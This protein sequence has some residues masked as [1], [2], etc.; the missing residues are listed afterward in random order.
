MEQKET[1]LNPFTGREIIIGGRTY[2]LVERSL[3]N[4]LREGCDQEPQARGR[5]YCGNRVNIP[6]GYIRA[7][8]KYECLRK[9][10]G[11]GKCGVY[12]KFNQG[13]I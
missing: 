8:T 2:R 7:G 6:E 11:A 9:G 13:F 5:V 12:K 3:L 1:V 4:W 10:F